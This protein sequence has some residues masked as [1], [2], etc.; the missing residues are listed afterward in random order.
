MSEQICGEKMQS[1]CMAVVRDLQ[2][3]ER[4]CLELQPGKS[5]NLA[6]SMLSK[7]KAQSDC[8]DLFKVKP[9][10]TIMCRGSVAQK[11]KELPVARGSR[12]WEI[13]EMLHLAGIPVYHEHICGK[14]LKSGLVVMILQGERK[15]LRQG[16]RVLED[17][18]LV[19]P[20]LYLV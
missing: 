19:K 20:I 11:F 18:S 8:N 1:C 16:C 17:I 12:P 13:S 5:T 7:P 4:T 3:A 10:G 9:I 15:H 2:T 14:A 6:I